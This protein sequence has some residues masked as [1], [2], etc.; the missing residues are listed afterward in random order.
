[1][2]QELERVNRNPQ[3]MWLNAL[4]SYREVPPG[5]WHMPS[6]FKARVAPKYFSKVYSVPG[7]TGA[8]YAQRF[9]EEHGLAGCTFTKAMSDALTCADRLLLE[10]RAPDL[11][12]SVSLEYLARKAYGIELA[13]GACRTEADWRKPKQAGKEWQSK[14]DWDLLHRTDPGDTSQGFTGD[15]MR[16]VQDEVAAGMRRDAELA[17]AKIKI[18]GR[19]DFSDPLNL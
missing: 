10:D 9:L 14:V 16:E 7:R 17:K 6:G 11:V 13:F 19:V 12:N 18:H 4:K 1:M 2:I 15:Y 3:D 5:Q 8:M